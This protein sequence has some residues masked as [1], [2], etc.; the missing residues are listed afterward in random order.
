[1][2]SG[3]TQKEIVAKCISYV[4]LLGMH[5]AQLESSLIQR[6]VCSPSHTV[7]T[8]LQLQLPT[9]NSFPGVDT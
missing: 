5:M 8:H 1:M 2:Q 6:C 9:L 3:A 7:C 4:E